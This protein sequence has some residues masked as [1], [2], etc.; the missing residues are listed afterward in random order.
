ME[1]VCKV[2]EELTE[3]N[4]KDYKM[5]IRRVQINDEGQMKQ[6]VW[7]RGGVLMIFLQYIP[8]YLC[9]GLRIYIDW[10]YILCMVE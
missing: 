4:G 6:K 2:E 1:D 7:T 10:L 9:S 8:L 5:K 3:G